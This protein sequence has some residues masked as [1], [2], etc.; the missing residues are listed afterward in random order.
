MKSSRKVA[1]FLLLLG[2][3]PLTSACALT[4]DH[5]SLPAVQEAGQVRK[6]VF[7]D[8]K[9]PLEGRENQS[10]AS[11]E[12]TSKQPSEITTR[13]ITTIDLKNESIAG[14]APK[15]SEKEF[16]E[17]RPSS[18][19]KVE[20]GMEQDQLVLYRFDDGLNVGF[21]KKKP[22]ETVTVETVF[23]ESGAYG[24]A[25]GI[26]LG[27][28]EAEVFA[29]YGEPAAKQTNSDGTWWSYYSQDGV[30]LSFVLN[31]GMIKKIYLQTGA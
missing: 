9:L 2:L 13:P 10:N 31:Y 27:M 1:I 24:T 7:V 4:T 14:I 18:V 21:R 11:G 8:E 26:K 16:Q 25:K 22:D 23:I 28:T 6:E 17:K 30:Q 20:K 5:P 19:P 15:M 29:A 3:P 12:P